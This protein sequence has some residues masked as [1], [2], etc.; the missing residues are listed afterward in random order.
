MNT[1]DDSFWDDVWCVSWSL[2]KISTWK[3]GL[4][5]NGIPGDFGN[6]FFEMFLSTAI[7][8]R[9][10]EDYSKNIRE[11][12]ILA[13]LKKLKESPWARIMTYREYHSPISR[14][15]NFPQTIPEEILVTDENRATVAALDEQ[16]D[17]MNSEVDSL[18][19]SWI[20]DLEKFISAYNTSLFLI[21]WKTE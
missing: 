8:M 5:P 20:F 3:K 16:I 19:H 6:T 2:E 21:Y 14:S 15:G 18:E 11:Y 12:I 7:Y 13:L 9:A 4:T 10:W 17:I 1:P